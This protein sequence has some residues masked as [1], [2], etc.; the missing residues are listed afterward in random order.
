[1]KYFKRVLILFISITFLSSCLSVQAYE[2]MYINDSEMELS[3]KKIE[4]FEINFQTY[5]EGTAGANGGKSRWR[6]WM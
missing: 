4:S 6:M 3:T 1:M 2:K 5:R